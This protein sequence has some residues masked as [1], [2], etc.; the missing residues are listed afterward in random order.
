MDH[1]TKQYESEKQENQ[2]SYSQ[3]QIGVDYSIKEQ[4]LDILAMNKCTQ[5]FITIILN[6]NYFQ[7][8]ESKSNVQRVKAILLSKI[9]VDKI[10]KGFEQPSQTQIV[11]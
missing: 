5:S 3:N 1:D 9:Q 2:Q 7:Q 10:I 11:L 8:Y 6:I 4:Q